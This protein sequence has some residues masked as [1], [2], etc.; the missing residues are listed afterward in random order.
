MPLRQQSIL[1]R[2]GSD[3]AQVVPVKKTDQD[4]TNAGA[5][6]EPERPRRGSANA[7]ICAW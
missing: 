5:S 4:Q 6:G 3:S 2:A 1:I 7:G